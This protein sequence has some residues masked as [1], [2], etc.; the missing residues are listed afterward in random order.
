MTLQSN[1]VSGEA[2]LSFKGVG[3]LQVVF[4]I[5]KRHLSGSPQST[6]QPKTALDILTDKGRFTAAP[7]AIG[8][9]NVQFGALVFKLH[10]RDPYLPSRLS[11]PAVES[12]HAADRAA[13]PV[14]VTVPV[15]NGKKIA[16]A[17]QDLD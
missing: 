5:D 15:R 3:E 8:H 12:G 4:S 16:G 7:S 11:K 9:E 2:N 17:F 14:V 1:T 10:D 6:L 13:K